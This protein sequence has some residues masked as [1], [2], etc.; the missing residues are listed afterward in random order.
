MK[1]HLEAKLDFFEHL[2]W[3][4]TPVLGYV[5][6]SL[7]NS[8][9]RRKFSFSSCSHLLF[10]RWDISKINEVF[11]YTIFTNA[12]ETFKYTILAETEKHNSL[13]LYL[14]S[15][16]TWR[17]AVRDFDIKRVFCS[18]LG[19]AKVHGEILTPGDKDHTLHHSPDRQ[20]SWLWLGKT[21]RS[22]CAACI[23]GNL[24]WKTSP[25]G[26]GCS[27][28]PHPWCH[29][30]TSATTQSHWEAAHRLLAKGNIHSLAHW[31][32]GTMSY[33]GKTICCLFPYCLS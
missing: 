20:V 14:Q 27:R 9:K 31:L 3:H 22:L 25:K 26:R 2:K 16:R 30:H 24:L 21:P 15:A 8:S 6:C 33:Q 12:F 1:P 19:R 18:A 10:L 28:S 29:I 7:S 17:E 5:S 23:S 4:C 32:C 11:W 13:V